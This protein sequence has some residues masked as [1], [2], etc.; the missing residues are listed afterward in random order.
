M[1][2]LN[3]GKQIKGSNAGMTTILLHT[4]HSG[5]QSGINIDKL[6]LSVHLIVVSLAMEILKPMVFTLTVVLASKN[7]EKKS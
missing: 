2:P 5:H 6:F 1:E 4:K 7:E 3:K